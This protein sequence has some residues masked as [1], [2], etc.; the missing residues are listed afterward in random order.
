MKS[1]F[2]DYL[3][4]PHVTA[5]NAR[6]LSLVPSLTELLFDLE[7]DSK[8]VGRTHYCIHP[9]EK[10]AKIPAVGG[11]KKINMGRVLKLAPTHALLNIDE[12]PKDMAH[13][14]E[15]LGIEVITTHPMHPN[16]NIL[17]YK[18][19][20]GIFGA[21]EKAAQLAQDF[22][23]ARIKLGSATTRPSKRVAYLI[24]KDP[25]MAISHD[26]YIAEMLR[27]VNWQIMVPGSNPHADGDLI[28]YPT[29]ILNEA[30]L[31]DLDLVLF[32]TEPYAFTKDDIARF[33]ETFPDHADKAHLIDGEMT[34]WYGSR[35]IRGLAYLDHFATSVVT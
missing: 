2:T 22:E 33:Q 21:S 29:V 1:R 26:T 11:T 35:A 18:L 25:W 31:A 19:V 34:S 10:I 17:L 32:S 8:L 15:S 13:D 30:G 14:L 9:A 6:I 27:L 4:Q 28:R 23:T 5:E 16:D 20:G 12:N 7:L 3:N 24:W